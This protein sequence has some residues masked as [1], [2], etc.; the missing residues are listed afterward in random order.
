MH[1]SAR[2]DL[3]RPRALASTALL[4]LALCLTLAP[5]TA[6]AGTI[7]VTFSATVSVAFGDLGAVLSGGETVTG[8]IELDDSVVGVFTPGSVFLRGEMLYTGAVLSMT[9][10]VDGNPISGMG[11]DVE[12][13]DSDGPLNGDDSY[14]VT[15][16][17][18]T[19]TVAGVV[20]AS[21]RFTPAYDDPAFT[22]SAGTPLFP[23]PPIDPAKA[24]RILLTSDSGDTAFGN[25]DSFTV[26]GAQTVPVFSPIG[27]ALAT[28]ALV[29]IG[30]RRSA[31]SR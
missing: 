23:P 9:L 6:R 31:R 21:F 29:G 16:V 19:G 20:P 10:L 15:G 28:A 4:C 1:R 22:F 3:V 13:F 11:G 30:F 2:Q 24:N 25:L 27:L 26:V 12:L 8:T 18:D 7:V 5:A 17:V 14:E